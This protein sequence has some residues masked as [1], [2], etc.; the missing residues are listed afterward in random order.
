LRSGALHSES[1]NAVWRA[2]G[3]DFVDADLECIKLGLGQSFGEDHSGGNHCEET[4][5]G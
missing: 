3:V 5:L 4:M 1:V 2:V